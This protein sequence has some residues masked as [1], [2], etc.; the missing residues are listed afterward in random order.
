MSG[1]DVV[2]LDAAGV[3]AGLEDLAEILEDCVAGG[4]SVNFLA[5]YSKQQA[6]DFFRKL[7]GEVE[8]GDIVILVALSGGRIVG[9]VQL[10]L[11]MPPNQLHRAE[12]KKLLVHRRARG[13]GIGSALMGQIESEAKARDR[14][15][16]VLDTAVE[17]GAEGLYARAGW[18]KAGVIPNY[19]L[20]PDGRFCDAAIYWK[21]I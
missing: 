1:P 6:T 17:G 10:D 8:R 5:P 20:W 19:A 13:Q 14:T 11:A 16:L 7:I 2:L 21:E 3:R 12:V 9:T 4:A 18:L 15:L